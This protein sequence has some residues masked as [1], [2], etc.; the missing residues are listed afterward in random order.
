MVPP[1]DRVAARSK[2]LGEA[3]AFGCDATCIATRCVWAL[4]GPGIGGTAGWRYRL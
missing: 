2:A 1:M 3:G 4:L